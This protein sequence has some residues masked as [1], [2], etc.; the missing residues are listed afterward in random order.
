MMKFE[1]RI[2]CNTMDIRDFCFRGQNNL[3]QT[4]TFYK[5]SMIGV[6][7]NSHDGEEPDNGG[8]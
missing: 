4:L 2:W 7:K 6:A 3:R 8:S 5:T 1:S